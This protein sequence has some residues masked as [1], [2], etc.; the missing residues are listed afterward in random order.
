MSAV[1]QRIRT[2]A[3]SILFNRSLS[4]DVFLGII[5][6]RWLSHAYTRIIDTEVHILCNSILCMLFGNADAL[7]KN[8][9][10]LAIRFLTTIKFKRLQLVL[11]IKTKIVLK[12][13]PN[14]I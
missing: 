4:E 13:V 2:K 11:Q 1:Y 6:L 3:F 12:A 8:E 9:I 5:F 10:V 14:T 7:R